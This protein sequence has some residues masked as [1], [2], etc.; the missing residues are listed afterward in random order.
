[1]ESILGW[2]IETISRV[3]S[4]IS[5]PP[6]PGYIAIVLVALFLMLCSQA[7]G[8]GRPAVWPLSIPAV[9][10]TSYAVYEAGISEKDYNIRVDLL[11]ILPVLLFTT[12]GIYESWLKRY[13]RISRGRAQLP[14]NESAETLGTDNIGDG[15]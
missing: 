3:V 5:T 1:M 8:N 4:F 12:V 13:W 14:G 9:L 2:I 6:C 15:K 11:V 7:S 10:W